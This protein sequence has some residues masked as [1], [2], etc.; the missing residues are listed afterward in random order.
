MEKRNVSE[1]VFGRWTQ[2]L[3]LVSYIKKFK[4]EMWV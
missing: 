4:G 2:I 3:E 1:I